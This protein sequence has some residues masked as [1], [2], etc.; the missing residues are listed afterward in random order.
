L[1]YFMVIWNIFPFWYVPR[2]IWQVSFQKS[3]DRNFD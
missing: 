3:H 2:K 1:V